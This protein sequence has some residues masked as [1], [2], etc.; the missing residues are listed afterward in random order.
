MSVIIKYDYILCLQVV[1]Y[2]GMKHQS[3]SADIQGNQCFC[4]VWSNAAAIMI[5]T[6]S[7]G[8]YQTTEK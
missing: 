4:P 8:N 7:D 5:Q 2:Q 3:R 1:L 6:K